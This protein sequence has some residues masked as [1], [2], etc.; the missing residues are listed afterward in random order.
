MNRGST[1]RHI[2]NYVV[3]AWQHSLLISEFQTIYLLRYCI[4]LECIFT[5]RTHNKFNKYHPRQNRSP[6]KIVWDASY[7][8]IFIHT[9]FVEICQI[10]F[11]LK[12]KLGMS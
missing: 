1:T 3:V 12:K 7:T 6:Q 10:L 11:Y 2:K 4:Y 8:I 5:L 9:K